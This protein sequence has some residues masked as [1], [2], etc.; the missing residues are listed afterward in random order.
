TPDEIAAA[1]SAT[2]RAHAQALYVLDN[3]FFVA[4]RQMILEATSK[5]RLPV[6]GDRAFAESGALLSYGPNFADLY[7]RAA[8]YVDKILTGA[9]PSELPIEQP[10]KFELIVNVKAARTLGITV[11]ESILL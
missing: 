10:T 3:A 5:G 9:K 1:L 6:F 8:G 4:H 7:R 11:P 2:T